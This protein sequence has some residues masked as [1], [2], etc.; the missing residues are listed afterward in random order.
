LNLPLRVRECD[1]C[2][3]FEGAVDAKAA[4]NYVEIPGT[5]V[6]AVRPR[7]ERDVLRMFDGDSVTVLEIE[8]ERL[9]RS[10]S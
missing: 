7:I 8:N 1:V 4:R 3:R 6:R 5:A 10:L 9:K 2:D